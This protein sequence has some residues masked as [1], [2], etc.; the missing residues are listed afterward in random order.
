VLILGVFVAGLLGYTLLS[1]VLDARSLTPQIALFALGLLLGIVVADTPE[2]GIDVDLLH[3]AGEVALILCLFV[4]AARI[5]VRALRGSA[6]LPIRLLSIGLPLTIGAGFIAAMILFPGIDPIDA[7]LLA[8]LIAPTDAA[9]GAIVV[10]AESIPLRIRQALNVESGLNDGIVTPLVLILVA[11]ASAEGEVGASDWV[12][13]AVA[14]VGFGVVGGLAVGVATAWLLRLAVGRRW[15]LEGSRWMIA[16]A[17]AF[18]AVFVSDTLG[19]NQFVAAFVAGMSMTAVYGRLPDA[20][21]WFGE[22]AG[23]L[24]G[25][26]VFF[27]FGVVVPTLAFEPGVV[28]FAVVALTVVRMGPVAISL[29]GTGLTM[30]TVAFVGWFGPRGLAS[31]VLALVAFGP[32]SGSPAGFDV[33]VLSAV[34]ATVALSVLAHGLSAGPAVRAYAGAMTGRDEGLAEYAPSVPVPSRQRMHDRPV[35][36]ISPSDPGSARTTDGSRDRG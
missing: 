26:A 5:D 29:V 35:L 6:Q 36:G 12:I 22:V 33:V 27:M 13:G 18:L 2:V 28:L 21:L 14:Q 23:E 34:A 1:R 24:V 8:V 10:T 7:A 17:A 30:P 4:D 9:L 16:P 3:E 11:I 32:G 19:G 15:M 25:Y 20:S 31:I